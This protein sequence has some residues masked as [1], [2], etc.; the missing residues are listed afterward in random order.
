MVFIYF[1]LIVIKY[2][3]NIFFLNAPLSYVPTQNYKYV[4]QFTML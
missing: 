4:L 2:F 1:K 3:L